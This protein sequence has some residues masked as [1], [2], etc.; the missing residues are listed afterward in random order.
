MDFDYTITGQFLE[1]GD[2][3]S[4]THGVFSRYAIITLHDGAT[5]R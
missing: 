1:N 2:M 3:A 4:S 5:V